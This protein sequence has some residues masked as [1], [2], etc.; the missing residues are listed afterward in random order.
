MPWVRELAVD[1]LSLYF[2]PD[3]EKEDGH[4]AV[5]HEVEEVLLEAEQLG[6]EDD[7]ALPEGHV[8]ISP[9]RVHPDQASQRGN[10]QDNSTRRLDGDE[11]LS[12]LYDVPRTKDLLPGH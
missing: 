1:E 12:G 6:T 10:H 2:Q 9:R 8:R 4:E 5:V 3:E 7:R 11:G